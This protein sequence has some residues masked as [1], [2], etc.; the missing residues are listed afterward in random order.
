[1]NKPR[2]F[3]LDEFL[4]SSTARQKSIENMPSWEVVEHLN[5]LAIFLDGLREA[6]GSG[7]R[8]TSGYRNE[9]LNKVV[10]GVGNSV[11]MI[12]Y[13][14]DIVPVNGEFE[15]FV[16]FVESY[17]KGKDFDQLIIEKSKTSRWLH[18]ALYNNSHKQ[19]KAVFTM[20]LR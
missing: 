15:K 3:E 8:I 4:T 16:R 17:L 19:R 7:I 14:A 6:W 13:A 11:H 10:G 2:Y 20:D 18:L 5:E 9:A 12:G 1:M